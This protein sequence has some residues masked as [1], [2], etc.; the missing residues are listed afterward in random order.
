MDLFEEKNINLES[1]IDG[2]G[3]QKDESQNPFL[4]KAKDAVCKI[5]YKDSF[6]TGFFCSIPDTVL[7]VPFTVLITN[8][9]VYPQ[10]SNLAEEKFID[11]NINGN[12]KRIYFEGRGKWSDSKMDF[13]C[14]EIKEEDNIKTTFF[15]DDN[16]LKSN[17]SHEDY[18]N[19]SVTVYGINKN[20]NYKLNYSYGYIKN[21]KNSN[22]MH[23]CNTYRGFSE[24]VLSFEKLIVSLGFMMQAL[25][26]RN[27]I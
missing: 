6:G 27:L 24:D 14:I 13:T 15:L 9:H 10:D 16:I 3:M 8:C 21:I 4:T 11:I 19:K 1:D 25:M 23:T 5:T 26:E 2:K 17:Y 22:F 18:K 20:D 12:S 7:G